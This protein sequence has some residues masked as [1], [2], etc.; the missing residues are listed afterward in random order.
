[1]HVWECGGSSVF[2]AEAVFSSMTSGAILGES[3]CKL[4]GELDASAS[5]TAYANLATT[6]A[7]QLAL[8]RLSRAPRSP[9]LGG[10]GTLPR[11]QPAGPMHPSGPPSTAHA[12]THPRHQGQLALLAAH[13]PLSPPTLY[14]P[15]RGQSPQWRRLSPRPPVPPLLRLLAS[16]AVVAAL[17]PAPQRAPARPLISRRSGRARARPSA[18]PCS[19][20]HQSP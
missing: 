19:P 3:H 18:R 11:P 14:L 6:R 7:A 15:R 13:H 5:P 9:R 10:L 17:A 8:H 20:P 16:V 2:T 1:M 12:C 4:G